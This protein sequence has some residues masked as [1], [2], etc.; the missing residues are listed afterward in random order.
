MPTH[1]SDD[2]MKCDPPAG[3]AGCDW[4]SIAERLC[5]GRCID[6]RNICPWLLACRCLNPEMG[7][8]RGMQLERLV[9]RQPASVQV[10]AVAIPKDLIRLGEYE[11]RQ[12]RDEGTI[13]QIAASILDN[14]LFSPPGGVA[15]QI[16]HIDILMGSNR[17]LAVTSLLGWTEVP[18]RIFHWWGNNIWERK[19][20]AFQENSIR[21]Q[22]TLDEEVALIYAYWQQTGMTIRDIAKRFQKSKSWI[23]ERIAWGKRIYGDNTV[24]S[25]PVVEVDLESMKRRQ[26]P[27]ITLPKSEVRTW[28]S[29]IHDLG[30]APGNGHGNVRDDLRQT[31]QVL[32]ATLREQNVVSEAK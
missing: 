16:G 28:L 18:V 8:N 32:I 12:N 10:A 17:T 1:T 21:Q 19:I 26:P 14:G 23:Q 13:R 30:I 27:R 11:I 7:S 22:M 6:E 5:S 15:T 3:C 25:M 31:M 2:M 9:M 20:A 24:P 4:S 29:Q